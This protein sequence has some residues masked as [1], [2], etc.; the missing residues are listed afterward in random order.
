MLTCNADD[1]PQYVGAVVLSDGTKLPADM[2]I[3]GVGVS[4]ATAFLKSSKLALERDGSLVVDEHLRVVGTSN[5]YAVGDIAKF[6][7]KGGLSR[8]EHWGVAQNQGRV[9]ALNITGKATKYEHIPYFWTARGFVSI[10][11]ILMCVG[12]LWKELA[13]LWKR[14]WIRRYHPPRRRGRSIFSCF[15]HT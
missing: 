9:A 10:C 4:P 15:L 12:R 8:I 14:I 7:F 1:H 6:P 3:L 2:V 5:I 13:L 11:H